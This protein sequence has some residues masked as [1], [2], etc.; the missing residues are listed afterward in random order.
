MQISQEGIDLIKEF[1][2]CYLEQYYCPRGVS[3]IGI[4]TTRIDGQPVPEGLVITEAQAEDYL[5]RDL[6]YFERAVEKLV[7]I[8]LEQCQFD[9]LVSWCYN[10]GEG[11]L[12][13]STLLRK[14][15]QGDIQG[16]AAEF[17]KWNRSG[18]K[19][20]DGLTRRRLA[21]QAL[22]LGNR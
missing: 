15:N 2:G 5:H 22:F 3:T 16:A 10:L 1:E 14:L 11:N 17:P 18:G 4:G 13:K 8:P 20:L 21:E 12:E 7:T 9:A 19:V 6:S